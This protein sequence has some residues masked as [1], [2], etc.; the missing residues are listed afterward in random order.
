MICIELDD[1]LKIECDSYRIIQTPPS[2]GGYVD[3]PPKISL[4]L[5]FKN[6]IPKILSKLAIGG[7]IINE[8]IIYPEN[9]LPVIKLGMV[10]I[11]KENIT[12]S[13]STVCMEAL[14]INGDDYNH[15]DRRCKCGE[16]VYFWYVSNTMSKE[17]ALSPT[18]IKDIWNSEM[19]IFKCCKCFKKYMSDKND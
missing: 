15:I 12:L 6:T 17:F 19:V 4:F 16:R 9:N 7:K 2:Y 1:F 3:I 5:S 18:V 11:N 14:R 8:L 13:G 10:I